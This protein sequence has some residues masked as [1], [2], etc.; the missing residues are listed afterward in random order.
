[1]AT[2]KRQKQ[3]NKARLDKLRKAKKVADSVPLVTM[4]ADVTT[5]IPSVD[6]ER[7][8]KAVGDRDQKVWDAIVQFLLYFEE[9]HYQAYGHSAL[10]KINAFVQC[11]YSAIAL[12]GFNPSTPQALQMIQLAHLFHHLVASASYQ[13]NDA[14]LDAVMGQQN[15]IVKVFFLMNSRCKVQLHQS[16]L[17]D[18]NPTLASM[19]YMN[20]MLG[21]ATPTET[22]QKN[23]Y[24]HL[25]NMDERFE[26]PHHV[27]S[28]LYF[29]CTYHNPGAVQ[30]VKGIVNRAI[31]KRGLPTF[32]NTP[33]EGTP[34][35]AIVTSRWHRNHA[36][37]KSASPLVEQLVGKYKLTLVWTGP[38]DSMPTTT[39][40]DYFDNVINCY[41]EPG[42]GLHIPDE[43]KVNDFNM[44]YFPDIGMSDESIWL[45]NMRIAPI[46][47]VG[48]GHPDTTGPNN[49][50][51]YFVGGDIEK[52]ST[53]A[54]SETMVLLPGLAQEPAWPTAPRKLN[55][56]D[57]GIVRINCVWG[58]DK[59]NR[60][61][62]N[63]LAEINKAVGPGSKHEFHLFA[64]P[65]VNRYA[66][67]PPFM[68]EIRRLLPNATV[69]ALQEYY[70]YMEN[71]EMHDFSL[72]SFPFGCYNVLIESLYMG[73]PFLTLVGERF[74]NRAGA[75]LN[76]QIGMS[77]NNCENPRALV[78]AAAQLITS[79]PAL[80]RQRY[81]LASLDLKETLFTLKDEHFLKAVN[82]MLLNHPFTE[83]KIIGDDA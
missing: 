63:L 49:E 71:A 37:Y 8:M 20:F 43:M 77:E 53:D 1:L 44:V 26:P 33:C 29:A 67:L 24:R 79:P 21:I 13:D 27:L 10:L 70:D 78:E 80:Q 57:D 60:T 72:N 32:E 35:I 15:N 59:Y 48:Y 16:K 69:H 40:T 2:K 52:D 41:F 6:Y 82:Y 3:L 62:L 56:K 42:G 68:N 65:G 61:L 54:Y 51:D 64:S 17:F 4:P 36:V 18:A 73:L 34:H 47:A 14:V 75:Y 50:I 30:R 31:Q 22:I 11:V 25:E 45:S 38:T 12:E 19:W 28:G 74:Y 23:I 66:A 81:H 83:T 46:Q 76:D 55:Y 7:W 58:P 5:D 9:N 39:V